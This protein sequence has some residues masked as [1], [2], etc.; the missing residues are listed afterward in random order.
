MS[1][2]IAYTPISLNREF[3]ILKLL[4]RKFSKGV[5]NKSCDVV[6]VRRA[7]L[8]VTLAFDFNLAVLKVKADV[9]DPLRPEP[10]EEGDRRKTKTLNLLPDRGF[11]RHEE[12]CATIGGVAKLGG[13]EELDT[14]AECY[15]GE[16]RLQAEALK[17]A[18]TDKDVD[19]LQSGRGIGRVYVERPNLG[20]LLS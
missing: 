13:H 20:T 18:G 2:E 5:R 3:G 15:L 10:G 11:E 8:S 17:F 9:L 1:V 14:C 7:E 4:V 12:L 6:D 16:R 19:T